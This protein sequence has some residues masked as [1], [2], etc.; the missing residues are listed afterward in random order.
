MT[1]YIKKP[2]VNCVDFY[3]NYLPKVMETYMISYFIN[4]KGELLKF[5]DEFRK[6]Y[7]VSSDEIIRY[8]SDYLYLSENK[9]YYIYQVDQSLKYTNGIK[10]CSMFNFIDKGTINNKGL[11]LITHLKLFLDNNLKNIYN[12]YAFNKLVKGGV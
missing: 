12:M 1:I 9:H 4:H 7:G 6:A 10:Y 11:D 5:N 2:L 8:F 3:K